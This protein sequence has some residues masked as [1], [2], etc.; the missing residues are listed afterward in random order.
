M[1]WL[2]AS[3]AEQLGGQL[4]RGGYPEGEHPLRAT[5]ARGVGPAV[6]AVIE[7]YDLSHLIHNECEYLGKKVANMWWIR[8]FTENVK[9]ALPI[10]E[11]L[12][13]ALQEDIFPERRRK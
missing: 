2:D 4:L 3:D 5:Y 12:A 7:K 9:L 13:T 6:Q 1:P 11:E 8:H 10:A